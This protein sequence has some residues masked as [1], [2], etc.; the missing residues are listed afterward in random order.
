VQWSKLSW[1]EKGM[2]KEKSM[3]E[4]KFNWRTKTRRKVIKSPSLQT[5][6]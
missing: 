6:Q 3:E 1:K 5:H 4:E 2:G